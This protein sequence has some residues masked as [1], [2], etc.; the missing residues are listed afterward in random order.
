MIKANQLSEEQVRKVHNRVKR[1]FGYLAPQEK[2]GNNV[3]AWLR[4]H[5]PQLRCSVQV[6]KG[7][8]PHLIV[9]WVNHH[10]VAAVTAETMRASLKHFVQ[11]TRSG[12]SLPKFGQHPAVVVEPRFF[13]QMFGCVH[14]IE[15]VPKAPSA[16]QQAK[17]EA[18]LSRRQK[19]LLLNGVEDSGRD[20]GKRKI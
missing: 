3:R 7:R 13:T 16:E 9:S 2:V 18:Q 11:W 17:R 1:A 20:S 6:S 12:L 19:K 4:H 5:H 10:D 14:S 8:L 15:C